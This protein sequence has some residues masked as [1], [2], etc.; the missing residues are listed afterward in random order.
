MQQFIYK[1]VGFDKIVDGDTIYVTVDLGFRV[2]YQVRV[3]LKDVDAPEIYR[4]T[5]EE[6]AMGHV[7]KEKVHQLM[8][9]T[10]H[11]HDVYIKSKKT[12][13]YGRW[14]GTF[15]YLEGDKLVNMNLIIKKII[16]DTLG[17]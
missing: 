5:A 8:I 4:G 12:G 14:L 11:E 7:V 6:K 15:Y 16:K 2:K 10:F 17:E 13:K 3:R 9:S 1:V